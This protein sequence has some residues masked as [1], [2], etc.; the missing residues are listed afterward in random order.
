MKTE[1]RDVKSKGEVV[2]SIT[3]KI[4]ENMKEAVELAGS[5]AN[6]IAAVNKVTS[7]S[8]MNSARAAKVRPVS[9]QALL[10]RMAKEDPKIK[11]KI[12]ALLA[13]A[14]KGNKE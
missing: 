13:E 14:M 10:Q 4:A 12:D 3:I 6:V 9:P 11:A 7:D 8:A 5:E 1:K 2:D